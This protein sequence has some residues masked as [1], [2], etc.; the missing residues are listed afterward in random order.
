MEDDQP[1]CSIGVPTFNRPI[2]LATTID[3]LR[4][5]TYRNLEIIISDNASTDPQVEEICR[6]AAAEDMRIQYFRQPENRG[7]L[8]NFE[9]V[10]MRSTG[11]YFMWAADDDR[12]IPEYVAALIDL[13]MQQKGAALAT[14]ETQ[15]ET[16]EGTFEFFPQ[17]EAF[18]DGSPGS[19][20]DR[21]LRSLRLVTDNMIYG[22]FVREALFNGDKPATQMMGPSLNEHPLFAC[23]AKCGEF[24]CLP[25]V[26]LWKL[27]TRATLE[28]A[29]WE[30]CGGIR[31]NRLRWLRTFSN[32]RSV[33]N[34][35]LKAYDALGLPPEKTKALK[36]AACKRLYLHAVQCCVGWKPQASRALRQ[37]FW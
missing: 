13:L 26:G 15:Y 28:S 37:G 9:F 22:M 36:R 27:A 20:F 24:I 17:C 35:I 31:P 11:R 14:F 19:E 16:R 21:I 29:K 2:P 30:V 1:L 10:L 23:A 32:H 3:S 4:N 18:Y 7:A 33:L 5:Q 8:A 6:R 12:R 25:R 34:S